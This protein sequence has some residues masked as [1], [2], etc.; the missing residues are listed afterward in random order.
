MKHVHSLDLDFKYSK[1]NRSLLPNVDDENFYCKVCKRQHK[2]KAVY[3]QHLAILHK[4]D[5]RESMR[6]AGIGKPEYYCN[7]C[8]RPYSTAK[9]YERHLKTIHKVGVD[10]C[11]SSNSEETLSSNEESE[12]SN[13]NKKTHYCNQCKLDCKTKESY[14]SHI[15][16][17]HDDKKIDLFQQFNEMMEEKKRKL[18]QNQPLVE[19]KKPRKYLFGTIFEPGLMPDELSRE[20][21]CCACKRDFVNI[22]TYRGHLKNIHPEIMTITPVTPD[23]IP[24]PNHEHLYCSI[25]EKRAISKDVFHFHLKGVHAME[26]EE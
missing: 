2:T 19:K 10:K 6:A 9:S 24:D 25:C 8:Y 4:M 17:K 12:S 21:H 13:N 11:D 18:E 23:N 14:E 7:D 26:W 3:L 1:V 5:V 20:P 16:D 15:K 22:A